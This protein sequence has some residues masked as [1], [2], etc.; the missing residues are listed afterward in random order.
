MDSGGNHSA[1]R[2]AAFN[3]VLSHFNMAVR[4]APAAAATATAD[5]MQQ[6]QQQPW[7]VA[8]GHRLTRFSDGMKMPARGPLTANR[9]MV[10]VQA[11]GEPKGEGSRL[12]LY[13][14][15]VLCSAS[16]ECQQSLDADAGA[17]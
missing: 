11:Y 15:D 4:E 2:R 3:I 1:A 5:G 9:A 8:E 16:C 17:W 12:V 6:Q 7:N 10:L 14:L 13:V